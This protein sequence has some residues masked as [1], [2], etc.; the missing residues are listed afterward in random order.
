MR[1]PERIIFA[2]GE[3]L[4]AFAERTFAARGPGFAGDL[5]GFPVEIDPNLPGGT[6][7]VVHHGRVQLFK[8]STHPVEVLAMNEE[9]ATLPVA[10]SQEDAALARATNPA[11]PEAAPAPTEP[12]LQWFEYA[13]LPTHLQQVSRAFGELAHMVVTTLPRNA[14]RTVALRKLLEGKD[15][16]V[17]AAI[18]Q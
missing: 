1:H 14:E 2:S 6:F 17:R 8:L 13:H 18:S 15:A 9:A 12:M 7:A 4:A 16:A 11:A 10:A 5:F 3:E